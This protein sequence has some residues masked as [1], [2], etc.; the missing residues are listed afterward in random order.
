[1]QSKVNNRI[2]RK[3]I[4]FCLATSFFLII[5]FNCIAQYGPSLF[6]REDWKE[7]PATTP[8]TQQH[9]ANQEL[10]LSLYGSGKDSIRKSHHDRPIDDPYYIWSGMCIG[11]WAVTLKNKKSNVD[12]TGDA[13]VIWNSKQS[14]FR[15]LHLILKLADGTWLVSDQSEGQSKVWRIREFNIMDI[16][17]Y[18]LDIRDVYEK[19]PVENPDL[20]NVEEIG[21]TDLMPGGR[22]NACSRLD[23]IEVYGKPVKE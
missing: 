1:M 6:F 11:N 20:T 18:F 9:I 23:W 22:S 13:K 5:Q 12:L 19:R 3:F 17:W 4:Q 8:V 14:G 10:V 16:K 2:E 21:F 15:N 7:T